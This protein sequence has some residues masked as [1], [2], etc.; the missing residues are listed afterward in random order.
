MV[1]GPGP[2]Q[3]ARRR[4]AH[5][6]APGADGGQSYDSRALQSAPVQTPGTRTLHIHA[7]V[8]VL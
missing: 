5:D 1:D 2:A 6:P 8:F 7:R 4:A 3:G